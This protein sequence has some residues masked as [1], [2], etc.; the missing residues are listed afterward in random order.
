MTYSITLYT[1]IILT[2]VFLSRK[3]FAGVVG[4]ISHGL[5]PVIANPDRGEAISNR[6]TE[7]ASAEERHLAMK[8]L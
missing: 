7:I 3:V 6:V 2:I 4:N 1:C 8:G 5:S